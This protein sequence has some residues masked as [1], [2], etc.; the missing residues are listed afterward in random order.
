M[1][2][3]PCVCLPAT[4]AEC[5]I[6]AFCWLEWDRGTCCASSPSSCSPRG[7]ERGSRRIVRPFRLRKKCHLGWKGAPQRLKP[8]SLQSIYVR[9]DARFG[10]VGR[11]LQKH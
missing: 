5:P 8:D 2:C 3:W 10:E 7:G 11:T 6:Q 4:N 9:P 1:V